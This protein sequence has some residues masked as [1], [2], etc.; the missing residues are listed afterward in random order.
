M[1]LI[2]KSAICLIP[3]SLLGCMA[4]DKDP[5]GDPIDPPAM[6]RFDPNYGRPNDA[7]NRV[8]CITGI[9]IGNQF[10]TPDYTLYDEYSDHGQFIIPTSRLQPYDDVTVSFE[11]KVE[12][13]PKTVAFSFGEQFCWWWSIDTVTY[14]WRADTAYY[15]FETTLIT[16]N[17]WQAVEISNEIFDLA[18]GSFVESG[19]VI[20]LMEIGGFNL[21]NVKITHADG[22]EDVLV[23]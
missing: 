6:P 19:F 8:N 21:R 22:S 13:E 5:G 18:S 3:L 9:T 15:D 14:Q 17:E 4:E 20:R 12:D 1:S 7:Y 11:I 23:P 10:A 2:I 16:P